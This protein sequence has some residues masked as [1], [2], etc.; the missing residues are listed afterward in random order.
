MPPDPLP[1]DLP[2]TLFTGNL[3]GVDWTT[4]TWSDQGGGGVKEE[5]H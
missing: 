2:L 3:H 1:S 5:Y 4:D